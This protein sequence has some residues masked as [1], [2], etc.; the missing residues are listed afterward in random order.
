MKTVAVETLRQAGHEVLVSDLYAQNFNPVASAADFGSRARGDYLVYAMEQR[1]ASGNGTLAPD[2]TAEL[3]KLLWADLLILNFP[4]FWTSVPAI[5][6]G[7]IDRVLVSGVCYG[8]RRFYDRG[9]LK[10]KRAAL[11]FTIGGQRHMFAANGIH[12]PIE[13]YLQPIERGTLAYVGVSVLPAFTAWHVPYVT[14]H[15]RHAMLDDYRDWLARLPHAQ[16]KRFPSMDDY[17]AAMQ[18]LHAT[19]QATA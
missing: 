14:D 4:M 17:D 11:S 16:P 7:W 3:D 19:G 12:G 10:G 2:I 15:A 5:L 1:H 6:K 13:P 8:G 9:G 18:P